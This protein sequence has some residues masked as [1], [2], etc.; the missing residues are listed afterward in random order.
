MEKAQ[1]SAPRT[2]RLW[3]SRYQWV[4][5]GHLREPSLDATWDRVALAVSGVEVHHRDTWRERF[6]R[7]LGDFSFLPASQVL[8]SAGT[9]RHASLLPW[10]DLG[11]VDDSIQGIF[12]TL[13]E[14]MVTL[15]GGAGIRLDFSNLRPADAPAQASG[16]RATGPVS[17]LSLWVVGHAVLAAGHPNLPGMTATLRCD[18]PDVE[19]FIAPD[20][21]IETPSRMHRT[22]LISDA[23]MQ[24]VQEGAPWPLVFPHSGHGLPDGVEM[25]ERVRAR[26]A[27]PQRCRVHKR[28]PA[29]ALWQRILDAQLAHSGLQLEF[30]DRIE[31]SDNLWYLPQAPGGSA[32]SGA[33]NL[34]HCVH[35][36]AAGHLALDLERLKGVT[37][38]AVRFLDNVHDLSLHPLKPQEKTAHAVRRIGL[39]ITGLAALFEQ[40]GLAYGSLHS[41]KLTHEILRAVRD[42]AY[43]TSADMAREKGAFPAFDKVKFAAAAQV[44]DLPHALQDAIA[45][46]GIRNGALLHLEPDTAVDLLADNMAHGMAPIE[47]PGD[48]VRA[49][50][51]LTL[52]NVVQ[53]YTDGAVDVELQ[54]GANTS[55]EALGLALWQAWESS[56]KT[57][58]VK[59][60][61]LKAPVL[62]H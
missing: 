61:P 13:R 6:R 30:S 53:S 8:A 47:G 59:V 50:D 32:A 18:H 44:L 60:V 46:H 10:Y 4:A 19:T 62:T 21:T 54:M 24:A 41:L 26:G 22:L 28:V 16:A 52:A 49:E 15:Q 27:D 56:L 5:P 14:S 58:R 37:A 3:Q 40:L 48:P 25:C 2:E 35:Q 9:P 17:F 38:V 45:A 34:T 33:I 1:H 20:G 36:S 51:Q 42:T 43:Q 29:A 7:V 55:T 39:G 12:N 57:C 31:R 11:A 23:F